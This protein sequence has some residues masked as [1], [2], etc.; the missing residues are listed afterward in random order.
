MKGFLP[1]ASKVLA[2]GE[3]RRFRLLWGWKN[4]HGLF[5]ANTVWRG[6]DAVDALNRFTAAMPQAVSVRV[7]QEVKP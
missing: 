3:G 1:N 7:I 5:F 6:R 4:S 2:A